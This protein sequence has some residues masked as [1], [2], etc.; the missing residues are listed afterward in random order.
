MATDF[1]KRIAAVN[2]KA[3]VVVLSAGGNQDR[4]NKQADVAIAAGAKVLVVAPVV[5]TA[6]TQIILDAHA[7]HVKVISLDA[8]I[9]AHGLD[10]FAGYDSFRA[11]KLQAMY[12]LSHVR[13]HG[14][15]L[16]LNGS[17]NDP[18]DDNQRVGAYD[19]ILS[20]LQQKRYYGSAG[21]WFAPNP[22]KK[23]GEQ[24]M[25]QILRTNKNISI[26]GI[27]AVNDDVAAGVIQVLDSLRYRGHPVIVGRDASLVGASN[28]LRGKEA[29]TVYRPVHP[30]AVAA[31]DA[32]NAILTHKPIPKEFSNSYKL[33]EQ[34]GTVRAALLEPIRVTRDNIGSTVIK[35]KFVSRTALCADAVKLCRKYHI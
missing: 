15:L 31:A 25:R 5:P 9:P 12:I 17:S 34:Q 22:T 18:R 3:N 10:L 1:A 2:P 8:A 23:A 30:E 33:I 13:K 28:V 16:F 29:M 21:Y 24:L 32:A 19:R 7:R 14:N 11:G 27:V 35:D 4:Q 20:P 26:Q 6:A